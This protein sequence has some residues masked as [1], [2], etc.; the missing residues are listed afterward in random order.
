[1][2][3]EALVKVLTA[4]VEFVIGLIPTAGPPAWMA[5]TSDKLSAALAYSSGLGAWI[6]WPLVGTVFASVMGCVV[7]G[8][9]IKLVRIVASFFTAGGGSAA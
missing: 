2:I 9:T 6:P 5:T 8:L 3:V 1:M 7:L 4:I